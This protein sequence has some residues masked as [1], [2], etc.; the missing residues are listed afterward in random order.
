MSQ[1]YFKTSILL[2]LLS[3]SCA[4]K[5]FLTIQNQNFSQLRDFACAAAEDE[6]KKHPEMKTIALVEFENDFPS[7]FSAE[8]LKCLPRDVLK[9]IFAPYTYYTRKEIKHFSL[10]L[11]KESL[12]IYVADKVQEVILF[13]SVK[14]IQNYI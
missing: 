14:K 3:F 1:K 6:L 11:P 10:I 13:L 12:L 4:F 2:H 5:D 8:I 7:T 9:I